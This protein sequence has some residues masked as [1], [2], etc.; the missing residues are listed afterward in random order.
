MVRASTAESIH[1]RY[2]VVSRLYKLDVLTR[3]LE[4]ETFDGMLIFVQTKIATSELAKK[5]IARGYAATALNGDI[6]Q[7]QRERAI[8]CLKS[9]KLDIIVAT[10]VA[11]RGL[12]VDRISH[13]INYNIPF[14]T[15]RSP[16]FTE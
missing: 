9:G 12:D 10:D 7:K 13:V 16:V 2:W 11:A 15:T 6:Q 5:L 3:I 4:A 8:T 1:Q 14:S